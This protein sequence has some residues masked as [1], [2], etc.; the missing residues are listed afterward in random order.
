MTCVRGR[1]DGCQ[2]AVVGRGKPRPYKARGDYIV[3]TWA[4][5]AAPYM[6]SACFFPETFEKGTAYLFLLFSKRG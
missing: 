6:G 3:R 2:D 4:R 1:V 5:R